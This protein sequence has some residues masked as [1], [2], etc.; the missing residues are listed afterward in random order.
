MP[1]ARESEIGNIATTQR[2][3]QLIVGGDPAK[4]TLAA[5]ML[6]F[7]LNGPEN[8]HNQTELL[9]EKVS[10]EEWQEEIRKQADQYFRK[11]FNPMFLEFLKEFSSPLNVPDNKIS[12]SSP[13]YYKNEAK[14]LRL[15]QVQEH[16]DTINKSGKHWELFNFFVDRVNSEVTFFAD[17]KKVVVELI[18]K[19]EISK[20][21]KS[22]SEA[23]LKF[24][25][26]GKVSVHKTFKDYIGE[27]K[28]KQ[29]RRSET[30][31][32]ANSEGITVPITVLSG[33]NEAGL[34]FEID[35]KDLPENGM[36]RLSF[37]DQEGTDDNGK[38][39][40]SN[41]KNNIHQVKHTRIVGKDTH[42]QPSQEQYHSLR[43]EGFEF[44]GELLKEAVLEY[45]DGA[46]AG[47]DLKSQS[48][49]GPISLKPDNNNADFLWIKDENNIA[50]L[51]QKTQEHYDRK[52]VY[53]FMEKRANLTASYLPDQKRMIIHLNL[54]DKSESAVEMAIYKLFRN[55]LGKEILINLKKGVSKGS[56]N[57]LSYDINDLELFEHG[58]VDIHFTKVSAD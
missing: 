23:I 7:L 18:F 31:K 39:S 48:Y 56:F 17:E 8:K 6:P 15:H 36:V 43:D 26:N 42:P 34:Y 58:Y 13:H 29:S 38:Y 53:Y 35:F 3:L 24:F 11:I 9:P 21:S 45:V 54:K 52:G 50:H 57:G 1:S 30:K 2:E 47:S 32:A 12:F 25:V 33:V 5:N 51:R 14:R 37:Q 19:D 4:Y 49:A 16:L 20:N 40:F 44:L 28:L 22:I 10:I 27:I 41:R 55:D 46:G